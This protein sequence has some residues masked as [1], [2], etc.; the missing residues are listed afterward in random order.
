MGAKWEVK[1]LQEIMTQLWPWYVSGPLLGLIVPLLLWLGNKDF[2]I[3]A[4]LRHI[5]AMWP[6]KKPAFFQYDWRGQTWNLVFM[7]GLVAGG[8]VAAFLYP[9]DSVHLNPTVLERLHAWGLGSPQSIVPPELF[10]TSVL[11][12]WKAWA[13]LLGGGFLIGFGARYGGGCTSGHAISGLAMLQLP[14]LVAVVFFF[15]GGLISAW[16]I[17]PRVVVWLIGGGA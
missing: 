8:W 11:A 3:S 12:S 9:G 1:D 13:Y 4:N 5:C 7:L 16:W 2:G 10:A 15:V 6:G 14:S 17:V